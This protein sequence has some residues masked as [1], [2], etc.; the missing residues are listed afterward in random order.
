MTQNRKTKPTT[1]GPTNGTEKA[2]RPARKTAL[3][4]LDET[5]AASVGAASGLHPSGTLPGSSPATGAGSMGSAG[6][7]TAGAAT[8]GAN[9]AKKHRAK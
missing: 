8:G 5:P 2:A 1:G 7:S 3:S 6:G 9:V 4:N